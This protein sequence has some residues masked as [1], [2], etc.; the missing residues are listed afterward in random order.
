MKFC[1]C[2]SEACT[3]VEHGLWPATPTKPVMA[4][5]FGL[6]ELVEK[7]FLVAKVSVQQCCASLPAFSH[8]PVSIMIVMIIPICTL[9]NMTVYY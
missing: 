5:T 9:P 4:F 3:L 2:K 8:F 6:M 1:R 7:M